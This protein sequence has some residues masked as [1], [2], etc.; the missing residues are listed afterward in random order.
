MKHA[1]SSLYYPLN[2]KPAFAK[3]TADE[4]RS[5]EPETLNHAFVVARP[6]TR[7]FNANFSEGREFPR[8]TPPSWRSARVYALRGLQPAANSRQPFPPEPYSTTNFPYSK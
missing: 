3:A 4:T 1:K 5:L 8:T 7:I 2:A 6:G